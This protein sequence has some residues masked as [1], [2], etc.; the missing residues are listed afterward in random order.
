MTVQCNARAQSANFSCAFA[1]CCNPECQTW[2]RW[3]GSPSRLSSIAVQHIVVCAGQGQSRA[4]EPLY[5]L[6]HLHYWGQACEP[7]A[8]LASICCAHRMLQSQDLR[9]PARCSWKHALS[10]SQHISLEQLGCHRVPRMYAEV[11]SEAFAAL[12]Q[13]PGHGNQN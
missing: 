12:S 6:S 8:G 9:R 10:G 2:A 3:R 11:L 1:R 4:A 5:L 13:H 7:C